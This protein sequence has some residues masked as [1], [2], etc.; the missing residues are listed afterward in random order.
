MNAPPQPSR[1]GGVP[2]ILPLLLVDLRERRDLAQRRI[3][4]PATE[5]SDLMQAIGE[6]NAL[7]TVIAV[8]DAYAELFGVETFPL[9]TRASLPRAG[10][11]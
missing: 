2:D 10:K 4:N 8:I 1:R 6:R 11:P 5:Y 7:K 9:K 3:N